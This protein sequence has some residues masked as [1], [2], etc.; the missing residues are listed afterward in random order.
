MKTIDDALE[1]RGRIF[2][3]FEMAESEQDPAMR[4]FWLTFVIVGAGPTGVEIAGQIAELARRS[5]RNNFRRID[6]SSARV[7]LLDAAPTLLGTF[8]PSLQDRARRQ[9]ERLGV[10]IG[11][12]AM[13][14]G[15]DARGIETNAT[16]PGL[17][18]IEAATKIWSAGVAGSPLGR[19]VAE[20][21]GAEVDRAGRVPVEP[22]CS[23]PGHPEAFVVGDLMALDHLPG[24][25]QVAIQSG[26]H[27]AKTIVRRT[28]GD[29]SV[30]PFRYWDKGTMATVS[31]FQA[32]ARIGRLQ[33]GGF[34][35]WMLWLGVHLFA[36]T[37]FKNRIATQFNWVVAFVGGARPQRAI[38]AGQVF[39]R[40]ALRGQAAVP[41]LPGADRYDRA[42][43]S[44]TFGSA[45][46]QQMWRPS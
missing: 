25:A 26:R 4:R 3:A 36:L 31:R 21:A 39:A 18:R 29:M 8:A 6:P 23:L 16:D 5:L 37:G 43:R 33:V 22:D 32:I 13:V 24:L 19:M 12:G 11:L 35:A 46:R 42:S 41:A 40:D 30:R 20:A 28:R 44:V 14:I 38:T 45:L 34:V 7:V 17:H 10:E 1:L 2:G 9:L 27:A 15:V